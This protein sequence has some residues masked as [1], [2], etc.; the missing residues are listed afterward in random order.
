LAGLAQSPSRLEQPLRARDSDLMVVG[1]RQLGVQ[2][3]RSDPAA[4]TIQPATEVRPGQTIDCGLAGTVMRFLPG[5]AASAAGSTRF[6][7]DRAATARPLAGLLDGLR[8][9][10]A[11]VDSDRLPFS[12]TG[13]IDG[14][15]AVIDAS[16]SSQ[17]VSGLLLA[18]ASF[19][20][21]LELRHRG[22]PI[23][24][25]P[26]IVMT[27]QALADRGVT[28]E[29]PDATTWR[30]AP[31]PIQGRHEVI[32]PDLTTAAVFLAAALVAGGSVNLPDWP[33]RSNQPGWA[34][35]ELLSQFGGSWR[36]DQDGLTMTGDGQLNGVELDLSDLSEL[37]CVAAALACLAS[38]P[39]SIR[40][41]GHIRGHETDRLAALSSQL[42]GL[43]ADCRETAD[44]LAIRPARLHGGPFRT[45][46][47]HR[48]AHAAAL[49]GLRQAGV[50]L[51]DV[52]VVT[53]TMPDFVTV[54]QG[55]LP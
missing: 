20:A 6:V 28:V 53:K 13:P 49:I 15:R 55:L 46:E 12:L 4:W 40:G 50:E 42:S 27:V 54:W 14:G 44:G 29:R 11:A 31:G 41:V 38:A 9:L 32:E 21:G 23:P 19:P 47:D 33:D 48:L 16:P 34:A 51:D 24:S 7:G 45:W 2:I 36:L 35:P 18:G 52:A 30:V 5:L 37:T 39:S 43:G 3:D 22:G 8:Q 10:G 26:H 1:L 25:Q 17:F